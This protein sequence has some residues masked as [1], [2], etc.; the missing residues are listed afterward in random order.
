VEQAAED[1]AAR[2]IINFKRIRNCIDDSVQ[3][4]DRLLCIRYIRALSASFALAST[5]FDH[6]KASVDSVPIEPTG[7]QH[8]PPTSFAKSFN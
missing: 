7:V 5:R 2:S 1:A 3:A 4:G 8:V 6:V